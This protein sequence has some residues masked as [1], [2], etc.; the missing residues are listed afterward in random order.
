[1]CPSLGTP[2]RYER[3]RSAG[4][5]K[6]L[7]P[8]RRCVTG[9]AEMISIKIKRASA[10]APSCCRG[11]NAATI[12]WSGWG[13]GPPEPRLSFQVGDFQNMV[14][15]CRVFPNAGLFSFFPKWSGCDQFSVL[16]NTKICNP[17]SSMAV[18]CGQ[19]RWFFRLF[20]GSI[21]MLVQIFCF[22]ED[23]ENWKFKFT[24]HHYYNNTMRK[25]QKQRV[26]S[27]VTTSELSVK[28]KNQPLTNAAGAQRFWH[29]LIKEV[30][31]KVLDYSEVGDR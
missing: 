12:L 5:K 22:Q 18:S 4:M 27:E 26:Q 10:A 20:E 6:L 16:A 21:S 1:M 8:C 29:S 23:G 2:T 19:M 24:F 9:L 17:Y 7:W 11:N 15:R 14:T 28:P 25:K 13:P 3:K 31:R 30:L